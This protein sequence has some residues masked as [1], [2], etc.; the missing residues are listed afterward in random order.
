MP[1][2]TVKAIVKSQCHY[3]IKV[4][5]N[6]KLLFNQMQSTC[7]RRAIETYRTLEFQKGRQEHRK[8]EVYHASGEQ[9]TKWRALKTFLKVTRWGERDGE[10]YEKTAYYISDLELKAKDF[11][12][13]IRQHWSIENCLHWIKDVIFKEDKCR[14]RIG[15]SPVNL[16]L[17]RSFAISV[18]AKT[19][20]QISQIMNLVTNKPDK[21]AELLE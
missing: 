20:N 5:A 7:S 15:N 19:G 17:I 9:K 21:I 3:V 8:L 13:G 12:A 16:S 18:L 10:A 6:Q 2:K 1:K 4:K 11:L 14:A